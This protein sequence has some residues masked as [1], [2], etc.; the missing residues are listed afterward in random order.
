MAPS[1]AVARSATTLSGMLGRNAATRSPRRTPRRSRPAR[2]RATWSRSSAAVRSCGGPGLRAADDDDVVVRAIGERECVLRVVERR[3]PGTTARRAC[4]DRRARRRA[5]SPTARRSGPRPTARTRRAPRPTS[6]RRRRSRR[7][8]GLARPRASR[9][10]GPCGFGRGRPAAAST[11][12]RARAPRTDRGSPPDCHACRDSLGRPPRSPA[13]RRRLNAQRIRDGGHRCPGSL[14]GGIAIAR[15]QAGGS[16]AEFERL[17][18][19][20]G[21]LRAPDGAPAQPA[22]FSASRGEARG[23][24]KARCDPDDGPA[25]AH[26]HTRRLPKEPPRCCPGEGVHPRANPLP[27]ARSIYRVG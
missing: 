24:S 14:N 22:A 21:R 13:P 5:A 6:A 8:G 3:R 20:P 15:V 7:G 17:R 25:A 27:R 18:V 16:A 12:P 26:K 9:G 1:D 2:Q 11:G 4:A 10:S 23:G 19:R